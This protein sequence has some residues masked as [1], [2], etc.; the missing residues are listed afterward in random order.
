MSDMRLPLWLGTGIM[1][2]MLSIDDAVRPDPL[3]KLS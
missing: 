3:F 1:S 2:Y